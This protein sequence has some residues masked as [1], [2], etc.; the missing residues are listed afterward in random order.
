MNPATSREEV[1]ARLHRLPVL[2]LVVQ[3]VIASFR[4]PDL[5]SLSL[6]HKIA[7]DQGLSA[8]ILRVAN[9]SFY[10]LPRRIGS[11]RDAMMV[12][13]LGN[14]RS[15]AL[16]VGLMDI[17]P[18]PA[19]GS[20]FDRSAY[21]RRSF[22]VASYSKALADCLAEGQ[23]MAF[24]AGMFHDIGQLVLDVCIPEQFAGLLERQR[25][26]G[27]G[28]IEAERSSLG[29]DH[30]EIGAEVARRWNFPPEIE[31]TIRCWRTPDEKPLEPLAGIVHVS[32]LLE[33]GLQD[34]E[35]MAHL[36]ETLRSRLEMRWA[37]IRPGLPERG[38]IDAAASQ[39]LAA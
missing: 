24:T 26:S 11:V 5:D 14:A 36:P 2:P 37:Q 30:A 32:V 1:F 27:Q 31:H 16:A 15:L 18:Q 33:G 39:L 25:V 7:L 12:L 10:G 13:G 19:A 29:F 23:P 22:R 20:A 9:S 38:Q 34:E 17:F 4:N 8:K 28:L 21:W 6:A 35:L 3:E